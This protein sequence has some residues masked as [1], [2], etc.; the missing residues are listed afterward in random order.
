MMPYPLH[1]NTHDTHEP[2]ATLGDTEPGPLDL[3]EHPA[4]TQARAD[5]ALPWWFWEAAAV[6]FIGTLAISAVWP[7]G[8]AA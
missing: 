8:W 6:V 4:I 1:S 5:T 7:W 2:V 3:V